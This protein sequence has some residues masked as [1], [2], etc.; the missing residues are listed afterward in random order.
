MYSCAWMNGQHQQVAPASQDATQFTFDTTRNQQAGSANNLYQYRVVNMGAQ[1][2]QNANSTNGTNRQMSNWTTSGAPQTTSFL[3]PTSR[4]N[5][6]YNKV[7][8]N[9][10]TNTQTGK[11]YGF[12]G[13]TQPHFYH[14]SAL[15]SSMQSLPGMLKANTPHPQ[16]DMSS[17]WTQPGHSKQPAKAQDG[18]IVSELQH[19][20]VQKTLYQNGSR[21]MTKPFSG[22]TATATSLQPDQEVY[23]NSL[24]SGST[25]SRQTVY[26]QNPTQNGAQ[27]GPSSSFPPSYSEAVTQS[28]RNNGNTTNSVRSGQFFHVSSTSQKTQ[29]YAPRPNTIHYPGGEATSAGNSNSFSRQSEINYYPSKVNETP[30]TYI[31]DIAR[32]VDSLQTS[33]P[34]RS[35]SSSYTSS[36]YRGQ[37]YVSEVRLKDSNQS[38]Q[39]VTSAVVQTYNSNINQVLRLH[40]GQSLPKSSQNVMSGAQ[41]FKSLQPQQSSVADGF[42]A[43]TTGDRSRDGNKADNA[44][45]K[46][47]SK[48]LHSVPL[49]RN[50]LESVSPQK[51]M[52]Q[53]VVA[54]SHEM[55]TSMK[56]SDGS[57]QSSPGRTGMRAVAV[58][59]PLSQEGCQ[60]ASKPSSSNTSDQLGECTTTDASLSNPD[61]LCISPDAKTRQAAYLSEDLKFCTENANQISSSKF[62][63][64]HSAASS[65]GTV[66]SSGSSGPQ[67]LSLKQLHVDDTGSELAINMQADKGVATAA[68]QSVTPKVPIS[69]NGDKE[70]CEMTTE[71]KRYLIPTTQWTKA[72]LTNLILDEEKLQ[73]ELNLTKF[74]AI[75][76]LS[77]FWGEKRKLLASDVPVWYKDLITEV[78]EF[79]DKQPTD[80]T[81][82]TQ[83]KHSFGNPLKLHHVLKDKEVYSEPRYKSSWLNVNDQ[84]D[85]IDKEFGFPWSLKFHIDTFETD[86]QQSEDVTV[87]SN[88]AQIVDEMPNDLL[89]KTELESVDPGEE[90]QASALVTSST[91]TSS[92]NKAETADST[93]PYYSFEIQVLPPEQAK[94]I[95]EQVTSETQQRMVVDSQPEK[96]S[97][98]E[99][100][101]DEAA[102][103]TLKESGLENQSVSPMEQVCCIAKWMEIIGGSNISSW[104]KCQCKKEL[105]HKDCTDRIPDMEETVAQKNDKLCL[106]E[107]HTKRHSATNEDNEVN[108]GENIDMT[109]SHPD[110]RN[111]LS[112]TI[113]LTEDE[114]KPHLFFDKEQNNICQISISDT[115]DSSI[116]IISEN[117]E[118]NSAESSPARHSD[119]SKQ[120]IKK[121]LSS[122]DINQTSDRGEDC[123]QAEQTSSSV[124]ETLLE[125]QEE[126]TLVGVTPALQA[127]SKCGTVESKRETLISDDRIFPI[128]Q[129]K[130][131][132]RKLP[133][134]LASQPVV[135][136]V[137]YKKD[138]DEAPHSESPVSIVKTVQLVLFG[139]ASQEKSVLHGIRKSHVLSPQSLSNGAWMAPKLLTVKVGALRG[140]TNVPPA[141]YSV[142]Q[143]IYEKWRS[144]FPPTELR[145]RRKLKT[146]K[147]TTASF[148]GVSVKKAETARPTNNRELPVSSKMS[149]CNKRTKRSLSLKKRNSLSSSIKAGED[150][151]KKDVKLKQT[152]YEEKNY[153][154][155]GNCAVMSRQENTGLTFV[156]LPNSFKFNYESSGRKKTTPPVSDTPNLIEETDKSPSTK[157]TQ[158]T[159]EKKYCPLPL[160]PVSITSSPLQMFSK[161]KHRKYT[162]VL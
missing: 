126:K 72:M 108:G 89:S 34:A 29:Q 12:S 87:N 21:E 1:P 39:P 113:A 156:V 102:G 138:F 97:S 42:D 128:F 3:K 71:Q 68:Q 144:S 159:S 32:I 18:T 132:K 9:S 80:C 103:V 119:D 47:R 109:S 114:N 123:A 111:E 137:K 81:V 53:F 117:E 52:M 75:K 79:C 131:K 93:D 158:N 63:I 66:S 64:K 40:S 101:V 124:T 106:R 121:V 6:H 143:Q 26:N 86:S 161:E 133:V 44:L 36:T 127:P 154:D 65:Y 50:L 58:V 96:V 100:K 162:A 8:Q 153:A 69:Q 147:C 160:R 41:P 95:F 130:L 149:L 48:F 155:G 88:P 94:I 59:Q 118:I 23:T 85:D 129:K 148:S 45:S 62:L 46:S 134:D 43:R 116:L 51:Q 120:D 90:K 16:Q 110:V 82:L 140:K 105:N 122:E 99:A 56:E 49:L 136:G 2:V 19:D 37:Q 61:H 115:S 150:E 38:A 142:K 145:L 54:D 83:V 146:P 57:I 20:R 91:G 141:P 13:T 55:L 17:H 10:T 73:T 14:S 22:Y 135:K 125:S 74:A 151:A 98:T 78:T 157:G 27:H 84:L 112:H 4:N 76:L 31:S 28:F 92:P 5:N 67:D 15:N 25:H 24:V 104:G 60:V 70:K 7:L 152:A 11:S 35:D 30:I 107:S 77:K 139:S 33:Y